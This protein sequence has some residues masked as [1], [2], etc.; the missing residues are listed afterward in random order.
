MA[1]WIVRAGKHGEYEQKFIQEKRV[2]LTWE[3]LNIDLA[4]FADQ[5]ELRAYMLRCYPESKPKTVQTQPGMALCPR[6]QGR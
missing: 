3:G 5:S 2:Y 6:N 4:Q 1:V